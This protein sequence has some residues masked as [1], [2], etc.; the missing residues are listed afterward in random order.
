[1]NNA[2][3]LILK[4][5][6]IIFFSINVVFGQTNAELK[7]KI[8]QEEKESIIK[9]ANRDILLAT[10]IKKQ[11]YDHFQCAGVG[12]IDKGLALDGGAIFYD[13]DTR[14]FICEFGMS[15]C[16]S[17]KDKRCNGKCPPIEWVENKCWEKRKE[18]LYK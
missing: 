10:S 7:E 1:M 14:E 5:P 15:Y 17:A 4:I 18:L 12:M 16:V 9:Y 2:F 8:E 3:T 6:I 11:R 13:V